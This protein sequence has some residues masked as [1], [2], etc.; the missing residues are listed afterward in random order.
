MH[1]SLALVIGVLVAVGA[2]LLYVAI[3]GITFIG[4]NAADEAALAATLFAVAAIIILIFAAG[5]KAQFTRVKTGKEAL[6]GA[7][8]K[9][10]T[11]L[12]PK[13]EVRVNSEFWEATA[14][15]TPIDAG[16]EVEVVSMDGNTLVVKLAEQKA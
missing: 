10:T 13:G 8:G 14:Q 11:D 12:K 4:L 5:F 3:Y 6:I 15:D 1:V 2:F 7:I 16:Q 9:A